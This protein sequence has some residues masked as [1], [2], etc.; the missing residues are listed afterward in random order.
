M[1]GMYV[2]AKVLLTQ[3]NVMAIGTRSNRKGIGNVKEL[4]DDLD[5]TVGSYTEIAEDILYD[6]TCSTLPKKYRYT[7]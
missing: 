7:F 5:E 6:K 1:F 2:Q 3:L 4:Y